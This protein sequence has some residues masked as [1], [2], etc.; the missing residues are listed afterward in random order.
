[1][2]KCGYYKLRVDLL[3]NFDGQWYWAEYSKFIVD[4]E[5]TGYTLHVGGYTGTAG[6]AMMAIGS[7]D[8]MDGA[9]F[10]TYDKDN[11][12]YAPGNCANGV[13]NYMVGGFWM[14]ACTRVC[15]NGATLTCG[16]S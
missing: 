1:L 16:F 8:T 10:T 14:N 5:S 2:R 12:K 3:S 13:A 15:I 6:D 4:A 9:K 7:A 11:D